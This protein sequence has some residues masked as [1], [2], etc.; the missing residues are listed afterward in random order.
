MFCK[1]FRVRESE[2]QVLKQFQRQQKNDDDERNMFGVIVI[3]I[4][5][6][7]FVNLHKHETSERKNQ[8]LEKHLVR[9]FSAHIRRHERRNIKYEKTIFELWH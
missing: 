5:A 8:R 3:C 6:D 7:G 9:Q 4:N 1:T 2:E